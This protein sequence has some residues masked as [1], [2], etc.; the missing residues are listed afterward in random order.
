MG[1]DVFRVYH[2]NRSQW[3]I[4]AYFTDLQP[5]GSGG[6]GAVCSA[7]DVRRN[8]TVAIK[9]LNR[10]YELPILTKRAYREI[11]VLRFIKH[12]N[13]IGLLDMFLSQVD[14]DSQPDIYLVTEYLPV[15]LYSVMRSQGYH[16]V[17]LTSTLVVV[18]PL[19]F[20]N[21]VVDASCNLK[22]ID[23]GLARPT[24]PGVDKT[25]Y[26]T[27]RYFR[28]PEVFTKPGLYDA[29]MDMWS[30]G[31]IMAELIIGRSLF[32]GSSPI[33]QVDAICQ[34]VGKPSDEFIATVPSEYARTYLQSLEDY[35]RQNFQEMFAGADPAA[36]DLLD[37]LLQFDERRRPTARDALRH[38]F[39]AEYHIEEDE[40]V[41]KDGQVYDATYERLD[42]DVA[43]WKAEQFPDVPLALMTPSAQ[44][45]F[46]AYQQSLVQQQ[47][48]PAEAGMLASIDAQL[49]ELRQQGQSSL[50][51]SA[52][53]EDEFVRS[54]LGEIEADDGIHDEQF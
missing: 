4:P 47:A 16:P 35:P 23:F 18:R 44:Q 48:A 9:K 43:G 13:V 42:L 19:F 39:F 11:K 33:H 1:D 3:K 41:V 17:L 10:A 37:R 5:V 22:I 49:A 2:V 30:V 7:F 15:D 29:A 21:I 12:E 14:V 20:S 24:A 6:Y 38:P 54:L 8:A 40:P 50:G 27:T 51:F 46:V 28:A 36:I 32:V 34:I 53:E 52:D 31:C 25:G 26:V 45:T